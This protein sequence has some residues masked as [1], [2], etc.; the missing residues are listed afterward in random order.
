MNHPVVFWSSV[1]AESVFNPRVISP[2]SYLVTY[3]FIII[4][5]VAVCDVCS[6]VWMHSCCG[7]HVEVRGQL[8]EISSLHHGFWG[9]DSGCQPCTARALDD[10]PSLCP[11]LF[12][13]LIIETGFL[14]SPSC[15][16]THFV[17]QTG[18]E[19]RDLP[20][21][22]SWVLGLKACATLPTCI[23]FWD[24]VSFQASLELTAILLPQGW[25][26]SHQCA[27][28]HF[29]FSKLVAFH[30]WFLAYLRHQTP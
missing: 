20:A 3:T 7:A 12:V 29:R 19:L 21:S 22:A 15:P 8:C 24:R 2:D 13:Y 4:L 17:D 18:L 25:V 27:V 9:L 30:C 6:W 11:C 28:Q 23:I 26:V 5:V 1:R 14:C 10:K 16:G